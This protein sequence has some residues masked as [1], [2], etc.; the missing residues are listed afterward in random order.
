MQWLIDIIKEW[1]DARF[2]QK[3]AY[4]DRGHHPAHDFT[5]GDFTVDNAWHNLDLSGLVPENAKGVNLHCVGS[6]T[7]AGEIIYVKPP[8]HTATFAS[9][10]L[11]SQ[12]AGVH[13]CFRRFFALD[14]N[15][16]LEYRIT[17][18]GWTNIQMSVKAWCF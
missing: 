13:N 8:S 11:R 10:S 6:S 2:V 18:D 16:I 5:F 7:N 9:C 17:G 15:R 1:A 12:V 4:V 14:S 3:P